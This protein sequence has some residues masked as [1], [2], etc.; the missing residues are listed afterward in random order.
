MRLTTKLSAFIALLS[1]LAM[2]LML[3]GCALS[4]FYLSNQRVE[5]RVQ[6]MVT[7]IDQALINEP[8]ASLEPWLRRMMPLLNIER[9]DIHNSLRTQLSLQRHQNALIEDEPNRF[10]QAE[11]PLLKHPALSVRI[12]WLDPANTWFRSFIGA[13]TMIA[14]ASVALIMMLILLLSHRWLYRHLKGLESLESRAQ[15]VILGE[16]ASVERG[17]IHEWPAKASSAIDLLLNDVQE[18]GEQRIRVD[19]LIRAFAAQDAKTGLNNRLF[20]DNQLATLLEDA[21]DVGAHGVVMMIR[22][23]DFDS[24]RDRSGNL[25]VGDYLFDLVN[26]LST[27]VMRYPGALL[28]RYFRSDF[29]V[30]LPHRTLK[31]AGSIASQLITAVDSLPPTRALDREDMIHIGISA[32]SNGQTTQQVMENVELATRHAAL[33]GGNNWSVGEGNTNEVGRGSVRWRTLLEHTLTLGG[34]RL[35]QKPAVTREGLVHHREMLTRIFDGEKELLAAEYMPLVQQMGMA[36]S[37]D[38]QLVTRI[39]TL[40]DVWPDETLALPVTVD[41][42]L[43]RPFQRWLR[44]TLLQC[45][46]MQRKRFLFELAEADVCQHIIRLQPVFRLLQGFGCRIAVNQAGL[47]VVSTAYLKQF[48]VEIIKL[49]PALVRDIERRTENQLFVQ[50]LIEVCKATPTRVF[51]AGVRTRAEWQTLSGLGVA[52]GQGDFFAASQPVNSNVKKYSQRYRV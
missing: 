23:P 12:V 29:A 45:T 41:A 13:S 26:M 48:K 47:T 33:L 28:A 35:Y 19:T 20:F 15:R 5:H 16:R 3:T 52:G 34:P 25:V 31:D 7:E 36:E 32:W 30:L 49:H 14:V 51:A 24:L 39:V 18:A 22:V 42:L 10:R 2:L 4:F 44:D 37:Y 50:S 46:K 40:S 27:F 9:I 21:E 38:R 1:A 6:T 17:S 8:V 43:Q 11:I